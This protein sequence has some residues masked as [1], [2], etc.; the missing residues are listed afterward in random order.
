MTDARSS[1][2]DPYPGMTPV[3]YYGPPPDA[4]SP[5][6][7]GGA[8][9]VVVSLFQVLQGISA[10]AEDTVYVTGVDYVYAF[11]V[12]T[13][14]WIHIVLGVLA[15][16]AGIG[17]LVR[18]TWAFVTGIVLAG[19][20]CLANFAFIPYYPVWSLI[21]IAFYLLVIWALSTR[22]S[23]REPTGQQHAAG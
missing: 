9:L 19:L 8:M 17:V 4:P 7:F 10:V 12:T 1:G 20:A 14:G 2:P 16:V 5:A 22:F 13:W 15:L 21:I 18:Q 6:G 3:A 23:R 11:D